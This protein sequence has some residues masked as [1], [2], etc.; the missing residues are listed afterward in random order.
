MSSA[1]SPRILPGNAPEKPTAAPELLRPEPVKPRRGRRWLLIAL[2]IM[3]VAGGVWIVRQQAGA[4]KPETAVLRT[5]TIAAGDLDR[6][7]RVSG[8]VTAEKF[9]ALMAPRL[10]GSR[11]ASGGFGAGGTKSVGTGSSAT[12]SSS[13]TASST[14]STS[15]PSSSSSATATGSGQNSSTAS[16]NTALNTQSATAGTAGA[17]ASSLGAIRGTTN[18]FTDRAAAQTN[19][20]KS[21][22]SG[23]SQSTS[24]TLGANGLG[25]TSAGLLGTGQGGG[26]GNAGGGGGGGGSDFSLVLLEVAKP[27]SH[28]KKGDIVAEFDRQ[29]QLNRLDDYKA[30]VAQLDANVKKLKADLAT[31][32][33][34]HRQ[35]V[36]SSKAN[37]DKALLDLKTAEVRSAIEAEDLQLAARETE[38]QYKQVAAEAKLVEGSQRSQIRASEIDRDQAKIE[39]DRATM[40]VNRMVVRA[41]MDGIVVMQSI[42][43]GGDFGQVQ[44][45][46]QIWPGMTFMQ[47]VDPSSMVIMGNVNQVDAESVR[48]GS[49]A[50]ARLDAYPGS[51]FAARVVGVGAMTKPGAWR[52][53]FMR[54]IPIRL[55]LEQIDPRVIPDL[56]ASTDILLASEKQATLAPLD[57][58]FFEAAKPFVFLQTSSGWQRREIELGLRNHVAA[59]VRAGVLPGDVVALERAASGKP[60]S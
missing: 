59:V 18:R 25:S 28:V 57:A 35:L 7:I 4:A 33:E 48:L 50:I 47:I 19:T 44:Q 10:R 41:P 53:N 22:A 26:G 37:W 21:T 58:V 20:N 60:P 11:N 30:T 43:R 14:S 27:G 5:A 55:K 12:S 52:P 29:Y 51:Q 2:V 8:I 6:T 45:G 56:S 40:N 32:E 16:T 9:A 17:P 3:A 31:A 15:S 24:S 46:D 49:K 42:W 1:P 38:A 54:E 39:L 13:S 23:S 34:A 36:N